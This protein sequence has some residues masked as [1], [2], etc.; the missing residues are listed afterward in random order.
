MV[1]SGHARGDGEGVVIG[2]EMSWS[3]AG[4]LGGEGGEWSRV[5]LDVARSLGCHAAWSF[6]LLWLAGWLAGWDARGCKVQK[7]ERQID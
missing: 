7:N 4:W 2:D 6:F 5:V 3:V 1:I